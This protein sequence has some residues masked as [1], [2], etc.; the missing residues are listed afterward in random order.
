MKKI[1]IILIAILVIA[2][3]FCLGYNSKNIDKSGKNDNSIAISNNS[4]TTNIVANQ[5]S[6]EEI[7][8]TSNSNTSSS[9][10][11]SD[12]YEAVLSQY[13]KAMSEFDLDDIDE[14]KIEKK[15]SLVNPILVAHVTRFSNMDVKLTYQL[16]DIDKNGTDELIVG[17]DGAPGA[18]YSYDTSKKSPVKIA[19]LDTMERGS[20]SVYENGTIETS[21]AGGA[22]VHYFEFGKITE[23][24]ISYELI[25]KVEEEYQGEGSKATYKDL[26]TNKT[27]N[28]RDAEEVIS[29]NTSG[30]KIVELEDYTEV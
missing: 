29:K 14:E 7:E 9:S 20:M 16:F 23:D 12:M 2:A 8:N 25:E 27:L 21:G 24:G 22:A 1:I 5:T 26:S 6:N 30:S 10:S 17:A 18:I 4:D 28:Y 19:F 15:Y 3:V 11:S 13:K